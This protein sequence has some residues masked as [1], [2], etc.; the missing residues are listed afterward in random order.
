LVLVTTESAVNIFSLAT[1]Y[2]TRTWLP[3]A[4]N[5]VELLPHLQH[6][7]NRTFTKLAGILPGSGHYSIPSK[8]EISTEPGA[9]HIEASQVGA[10]ELGD[11]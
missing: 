3:Q 10:V 1:W 5:A 9:V 6:E 2:T 8:V 7:T 4:E 11:E